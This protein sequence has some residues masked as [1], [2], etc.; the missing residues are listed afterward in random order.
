MLKTWT[1]RTK[2]E[3]DEGT[4]IAQ[5]ATL[6]VVDK[7]QDITVKGAFDGA[8]PVRVSRFNHSSAIRDDLPVG[9]ATIKEDG[10]AIIAEGRLNLET[11]GGRELY[12]TLKFEQSNNVSSE[13]S[14]GFTVEESEN[15]ERDDQ[16]V[17]VLKKLN[18]FE[19][20]PV[21]RGAG[22]NTATLAVKE[23]KTAT[24]F[25]DLPLFDRNYRWD[26]GAALG[27]VRKWAS[28]DGSGEKDSMDWPK[29]KKAFFWYDPNDDSNFS[30]F[31]LPFADITD[32][33]L[34]AV[35]RGIFA[36]AG[37]MQGARGGVQISPID[38]DHV[39]DTVDRY[40]EKMRGVFDDDSII[41]PWAKQF[42]GLSLKHE[43]DLALTA[44]DA[45][46]SRI[47][48][49]ADL[50]GKE[51]RLLSAA[52]HTRLCELSESLATVSHDLKGL[53]KSHEPPSQT[54]MD[55][56]DH[57]VEFHRIVSKYGRNTYAQ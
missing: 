55:V 33:E 40:Y 48:Q 52:N 44:I 28:R 39:K 1:G 45:L 37:V 47:T 20:S 13:W 49:L 11:A 7:D 46:Q 22:E 10:E 21:M 32:G 14:Y 25:A 2:V 24:D 9:V 5:I 56:L 23:D 34:R 30:G 18:P 54:E 15:E 35:P 16:K 51:G 4:F 8:G 3:G 50:R 27:R 26:S 36:V 42:T 6:N 53:A 19:V 29:Y 41:V 43:G 12:D 38:Q 57:L 31:K 17:R